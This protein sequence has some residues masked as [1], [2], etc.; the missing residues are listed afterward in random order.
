LNREHTKEKADLFESLGDY[1][2]DLSLYKTLIRAAI[3]EKELSKLIS[4]C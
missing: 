1:E 3:P 2:K 4:K